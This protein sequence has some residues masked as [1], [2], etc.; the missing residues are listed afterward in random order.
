MLNLRTPSLGRDI[1]GLVEERV[2]AR[3]PNWRG[4]MPREIIDQIWNQQA[5]GSGPLADTVLALDPIPQ[6]KCA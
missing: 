3:L 2:D 6:C 1:Y 4:L 5:H